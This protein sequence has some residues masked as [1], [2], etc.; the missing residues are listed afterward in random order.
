MSTP[1][2]A[3]SPPPP[4][5]PPA[6]LRRA[7][8][9]G[10]SCLSA[11]DWRRTVGSTNALAA[12]AA[13]RGVAEVHAVLADEQVAGRGRRGRGWWAP[14]GTSLMGSYVLRPPLPAARLPLLPLLVGLALAE[15]VAPHLPGVDVALKWPND[16]LVAGRKAAGV[17][18]EGP[19]HGAV[20]VGVGVNVDWR[21][22]KRPPE[23][24]EATSLAEAAGR[25]VDRWRVLAAFVGVLGNRYEDWKAHPEG[26]L[27]AYR[28]RCATIGAHVRVEPAG[29]RA[30]TGVA[31]AVADDGVLVV[32]RD[33]GALARVSAGDVVHVR[34]A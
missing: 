34:P 15:A 24:A 12:E 4:S 7:L 28:K 32:A 11:L 18:A 2:A 17:L 1:A 6:A 31:R 27:P 21:G 30:F 33:D 19:L 22:V 3:A 29:D 14:P 9:D 16:L 20:V 8:V 25:P 5:G 10:P 23:L 26:F 13:A